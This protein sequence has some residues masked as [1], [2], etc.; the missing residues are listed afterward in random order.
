M[1]RAFA[2]TIVGAPLLFRLGRVLPRRPRKVRPEELPP[3]PW[4]GHC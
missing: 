1:L 4:I 3:I 2:T